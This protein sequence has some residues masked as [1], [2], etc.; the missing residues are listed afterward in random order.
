MRAYL[1]E[2]NR[3]LLCQIEVM[4]ELI[5]SAKVA[6]E[7]TPYVGQVAQLC[8]GLRQQALRNLKDL[9]Y[10]IGGTL[11][12]ILAATQSLTALF[13]LVNT[14]LASPV[15]R[16]KEKEDRLGLLFLR[17]L[18]DSTTSTAPLP[19]GLTDGNFAVY[20]TSQMPP[21]YLLPVTRQTTL[22]Y[23]PLLYHE[24]G[25]LLYTCHKPEMD[26][27]VKEFQKVVSTTLAPQSIREKT[28]TRKA[29]F[30]RQV[31]TAWFAWV[32]EFFCDATGL[33]IGGPSYLKAFSHFFRTRSS[34]QYYVPRDEQLKRRHPVTWLRTKMLVDRAR[35][36]GHMQVADQVEQAW[37]ETAQAMAVQEDYEGTWFDDFLIPLRKTLDD[38]LE[39]TQPYRHRP[40]DVIPPDPTANLNPVQLCSQAWTQFETE[41]STYRA[42]EREAILRF[43]RSN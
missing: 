29:S 18:H 40:E 24:F 17:W 15:V 39:E 10:D 25:H 14:R 6:G 1:T 34:D 5:G 32:Q 38:M 28:G 8:A 35:S 19:F 21:I 11:G 16:A 22:L 3:D 36:L 2:A 43:L 23:V 7:L 42:W 41:H 9:E 33:T 12:D 13:E 37:T 4:Q 20:P 27:L 31:V 26:A 30:R